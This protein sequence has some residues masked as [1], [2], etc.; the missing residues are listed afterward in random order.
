VFVCRCTDP[1]ASG[2]GNKWGIRGAT[3]GEV[4]RGS[5]LTAEGVTVLDY[6]RQVP[7]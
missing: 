3:C 5:R 2:E 4:S 7:G 6:P 1:W